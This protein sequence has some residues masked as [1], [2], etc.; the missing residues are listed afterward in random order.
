VI[1]IA[2]RG[3]KNRLKRLTESRNQLTDIMITNRKEQEMDAD[4]KVITVNGV[5]YIPQNSV[6]EKEINSDIKIVVLQRG[7]IVVGR[8]ER[9]DTQ[10]K[11]HNASVSFNNRL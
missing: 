9:K 7:W 1:V 11:L 6:V 4:V 8:F 2:V 5:D 3:L 10:C